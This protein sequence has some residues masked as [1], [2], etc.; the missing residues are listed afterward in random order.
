MRWV[1]ILH[2]Y[3]LLAMAPLDHEQPT[4]SRSAVTSVAGVL[5]ADLLWGVPAT[6]DSIL[7]GPPGYQDA[8]MYQLALRLCTPFA[9]TP[10]V[11]G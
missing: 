9:K 4:C 2:Q 5:R 1:G 8:F 10:P 11:G 6:L 7:L 3:F